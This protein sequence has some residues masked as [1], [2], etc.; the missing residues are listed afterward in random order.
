MELHIPQLTQLPFNTFC[1]IFIT[2]TPKSL[3]SKYYFSPFF[4]NIFINWS[5]PNSK[6]ITPYPKIA[7]KIAAIIN[8]DQFVIDTTRLIKIIPI[9]KI[10]IATQVFITV[11]KKHFQG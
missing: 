2:T 10:G 9:I 8:P 1:D 6:I 3:Y 4:F 7:L 5:R 11:E